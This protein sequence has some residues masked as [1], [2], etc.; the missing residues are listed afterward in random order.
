MYPIPMLSVH[1]SSLFS[2]CGC[3]R[4]DPK[5]KL[6]VEEAHQRRQ[7]PED[8][9][10]HTEGREGGANGGDESA[11]SLEQVVEQAY[12]AGTKAFG[13]SPINEALASQFAVK[14]G[15]SFLSRLCLH[16]WRGQPALGAIRPDV[17]WTPSLTSSSPKTSGSTS[18]T[19]PVIRISFACR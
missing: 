7:L 11:P 13:Q 16:E 6:E 17:I 1:K 19:A 8:V 12:E 9:E 14:S 18:R 4:V 15:I 2:W 5:A 10:V 3:N